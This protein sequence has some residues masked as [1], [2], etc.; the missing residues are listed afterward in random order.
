MITRVFLPPI[1]AALV[2]A[3]VFVFGWL[4]LPAVGL[5]LLAALVLAGIALPWV[6]NRLGQWSEATIGEDRR[7]LA[8]AVIE[9]VDGAPEIVTYG[10]EEA[11]LA[12]V[13][14]IE[15]RLQG[16]AMRTA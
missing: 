16:K 12:E 6:A 3:M 2:V 5:V 13:G 10:Q 9:M 8:E 1:V 14:A 15:D 4:L 11:F 7:M